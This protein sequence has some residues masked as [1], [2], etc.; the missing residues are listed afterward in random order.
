MELRIAAPFLRREPHRASL[1]ARVTLPEREEEAWFSVE[2][3][4]EGLLAE[5]RADA[6]VVGFLPAAMELGRILSAKAP[7]QS[8][9]ITSL[10]N[11]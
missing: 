1:C 8:G 3:E 5:D 11:T 6:F 7:S 10:P 9:F 4:F 2:P